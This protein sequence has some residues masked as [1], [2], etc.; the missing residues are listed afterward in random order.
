MIGGYNHHAHRKLCFFAG[1][2]RLT[3]PGGAGERTQHAMKTPLAWHNLM[4]NRVR[5]A[6]AVAGVMFAVV[7]IFLQLGF[8]GATEKTAS[9]VYGALDF[10]LLI[11]SQ[12]TRRLAEAQPFPRNRLDQAASVAGVG[13]IHPFYVS[14]QR[15]RIPK[16]RDAGY[17]RRILLIG[18]QPGD[19]VFLSAE[20]QAKTALLTAPEFALI[21]RLSRAEFGPANGKHFGD[22]DIGACHEVGYQRVQLVGCYSLG[23]SFDADGSLVLSDKGFSRLLPGWDAEM[24][25]FGLVKLQSSGV[26]PD[27]VARK[28]KEVLLP[29]VEVLTK[30]E[31]I[32][33][34][35]RMWLWEMSIGIIFALGVGVA[36]VVGA[37][38]VYQI[39]SSDVT[40]HLPEY[41]TLKAMGYGDGFLGKVV[42]QQALFLSLFGFLPGLAVAEGL[43]WLA[44]TAAYIPI[45]MTF[46]RIVFVLGLSVVM[47]SLSGLAA[48]GKLRGAQPADL[49]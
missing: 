12:R 44:R 10:D 28:L 33:R 30:A 41:A 47:C 37:A 16:G 48:L 34:D 39:L 18:V 31:I 17:G 42:L 14:S 43:Y 46:G 9:L 35:R 25:S 8:F 29:D 5:T 21:D 24:V 36:L 6:A 49:F 13:E 15:W 22:E 1:S 38:I 20:L 27:A 23:A 19:P 4:H 7:L 26:D 40:S 2:A 11:R 3:G 32:A 45:D